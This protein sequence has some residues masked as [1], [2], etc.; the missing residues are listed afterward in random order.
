MLPDILLDNENFDEIIE[1]AKNMIVSIYPEWTDFNY[2]DPGVTMLELFA[3]LKEAQQYYLNKIGPENRQKYLKLMGIFRRHKV[4]ARTDVTM[5]YGDDIIVAEGTKFYAGELS[6]EAVRRTYI[7]SARIVCCI[8]EQAEGASVIGQRELGFGGDLKLKPFVRRTPADGAFYI[9]FDKPLPANEPLEL[10]ITVSDDGGIPRNPIREGDGFIPLVDMIAEYFDGAAWHRAKILGDTTYAFLCSGRLTVCL[11][12]DMAQTTLHGEEAYFLRLRITDGAYDTQ[13][14]IAA[15]D[16]NH[17]TLVQQD[18][19]AVSE[20]FPAAE[21]FIQATELGLTGKTRIFLRHR[22]G[23]FREAQTYNRIIDEETGAITCSGFDLTD[24]TG[25]RA[26]NFRD[27]FYT[28]GAF[29][30]GTGLPYQEYDLGST[31]IDYD[32]FTIMTEL[33]GSERKFAEWKKVA[34][35]ARSG[36]ADLHYILDS[37]TGILKFG[38][39]IRGMAPEGPILIVGCKLTEGAAGNV[40][41][42]KVNRLNG[43][44]ADEVTVY[45]SRPANGGK[46]E[47]TLDA[48]LARAHELLRTTETMVSAEDCEQRIMKTP[49]LRI[50]KCQVV[51][52]NSGTRRRADITTSVVVKPYSPDDR[53][54]PS[55]RYVENILK[56]TEKYRLLGTRLAIIA[57]EYALLTVFADINVSFGSTDAKR[58]VNDA[59][60]EYFR[61]VKDR[62]GAHISYSALYALIDKLDCVLSVNT[63]TLDA[64]GSDVTRTREGDLIL[65]PNVT[66][67]LAHT[68]YIINTV[69]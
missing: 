26:V 60:N 45:N 6:F 31:A 10:L 27:D 25:I 3:Q 29:G 20:D 61:S 55:R 35:F 16:F 52:M 2:H 42:R 28:D 5:L 66:A 37:D 22:D 59:V 50:E 39:C 48:C 43:F 21:S 8:G 14:L 57:P 15:L 17:V 24:C 13:P 51:N 4:P 36:P 46:D 53:G 38:D 68:D 33:P 9:G 11:P 65:A 49:G 30:T 23:F 44:S 40:A 41:A 47:E 64:S 19:K 63:L 18:T 62:F 1:T 56:Y 67:V 32:S 58:M 69:Y 54:I 34:D 12:A 7:P